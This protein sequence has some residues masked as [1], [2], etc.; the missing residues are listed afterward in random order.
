MHVP[1]SCCFDRHRIATGAESD[2]SQL[3]L[4]V[5]LAFAFFSDS[6]KLLQFLVRPGHHTDAADDVR[7][8][9]AHK[10]AGGIVDVPEYVEI[11]NEHRVMASANLV[12]CPS[13][14]HV[15]D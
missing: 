12:G 11:G 2:S 6:Q 7:S 1:K 3:N 14:D 5:V 9:E 15:A 10:T 4:L 8:A 13:T